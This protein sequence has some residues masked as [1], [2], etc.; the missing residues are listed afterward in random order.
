MKKEVLIVLGAPNSPTGELSN[1]AKSRLDYC[2]SI[3]SKGKR[4][5][6]TGGWGE[7]FNTAP[8]AHAVYAKRYLIEKGVF[9]EDFLAF[10]LSQNTVDDAIKVK[11]IISNITASKWTIITSDFHKERVV[12]IFQEI[13]KG[14]DFTFTGV[15]SNLENDHLERLIKHEQEAV[16]L[17]LRNGLYY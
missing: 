16:Q 7:H 14:F 4:V 3:Y 1:I 11:K 10:A 13:L 8:E 5:L 15:K 17:I 9:E 12:L 6:C 2:A